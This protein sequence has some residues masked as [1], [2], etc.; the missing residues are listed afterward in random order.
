M[1]DTQ[2]IAKFQEIV[3]NQKDFLDRADSL[4]RKCMPGAGLMLAEDID[5]YFADKEGVRFNEGAYDVADRN[6]EQ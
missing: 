4:L 3:V 6:G 2:I 5:R 1:T